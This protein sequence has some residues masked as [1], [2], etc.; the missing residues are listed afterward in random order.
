MTL[1][2]ELALM[3]DAIKHPQIKNQSTHSFGQ[4]LTEQARQFNADFEFQNRN[5]AEQSKQAA[6]QLGFNH[7]SSDWIG[8]PLN[9]A[10]M[11]RE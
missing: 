11:P 5:L 1:W 10:N 9:P 2:K 8:S 6:N 4:N 3:D 7:D